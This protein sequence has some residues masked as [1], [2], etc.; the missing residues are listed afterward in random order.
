MFQDLYPSTN[1]ADHRTGTTAN[2]GIAAQVLAPLDGLEEERFSLPS[3]FLVGGQGCFKI[4]E[5]ATGHRDA[6]APAG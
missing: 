5:Q 1:L 4:R 3:Q 6:I 2:K